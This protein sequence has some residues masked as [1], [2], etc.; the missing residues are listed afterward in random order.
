MCPLAYFTTKL[1]RIYGP[2][3]FHVNGNPNLLGSL[4]G[5]SVE[6]TFLTAYIDASTTKFHFC[7][8]FL[9]VPFPDCSPKQIENVLAEQLF[10][11]EKQGWLACCLP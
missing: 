7:K 11:Q 8:L 9:A 5:T 4:L 2:I 6:E 3:A 10:L 1:A